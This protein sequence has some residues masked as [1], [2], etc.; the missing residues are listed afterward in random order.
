MEQERSD[1]GAAVGCLFLLGIL[2]ACL[3]AAWKGLDSVG[4]IAHTKDTTITARADWFEGESKEC[5]SYPMDAQ[6]AQAVDSVY[7][8]SGPSREIK[9]TFWGRLSQPQYGLVN[10]KCTRDSHGFTCYDL[11]GEK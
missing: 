5:V 7:C 3:V 8:D 10:W 9:V 1:I 4:L 6:T 11:S 2:V